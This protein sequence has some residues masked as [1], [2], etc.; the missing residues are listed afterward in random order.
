MQDWV[1]AAEVAELAAALRATRRRHGLSQSEL[2][3][4]AGTGLRFISELERGKATV[5][6]EKVLA[7]AATLG[8]K[9]VLQD[10]DGAATAG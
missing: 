7:V 6:L 10:D 8:L 2:A 4:R 1:Q 3:G 5:S 9:L